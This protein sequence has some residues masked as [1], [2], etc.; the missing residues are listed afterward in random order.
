MISYAMT[1]PNNMISWA[2]GIYDRTIV[3][4]FGGII[5][6]PITPVLASI[7]RHADTRHRYE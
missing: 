5:F 6:L 1:S 4:Q 7:T 2:P 3:H